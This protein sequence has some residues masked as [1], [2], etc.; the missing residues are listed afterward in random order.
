MFRVGIVMTS[1]RQNRGALPLLC[2]P[3]KTNKKE[4]APQ[5]Q[6]LVLQLNNKYYLLISTFLFTTLPS[7]VINCIIYAPVW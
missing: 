7:L 5:E 3:K 4:A 2:R 1:F 6:P